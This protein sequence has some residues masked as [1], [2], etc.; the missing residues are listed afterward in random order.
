MGLRSG[1][2]WDG[3]GMAVEWRWN[4]GGIADCSR[5]TVGNTVDLE[6]LAPANLGVPA[7]EPGALDLCFE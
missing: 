2:R 5:D 4:G 1:W 7:E 3:G 6:G